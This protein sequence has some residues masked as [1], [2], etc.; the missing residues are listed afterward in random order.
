MTG[1]VV[2]RRHAEN[3]LTFFAGAGDL[4]VN[5]SASGGECGEKGR[6]GISTLS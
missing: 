4:P 2:M 5:Q 3:P 6:A 1:A